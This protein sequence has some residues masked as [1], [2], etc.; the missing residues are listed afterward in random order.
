MKA[1]LREAFIQG[2][3]KVQVWNFLPEWTVELLR[4]TGVIVCVCAGWGEYCLRLAC[5]TSRR[6]HCGQRALKNVPWT[7]AEDVQGHIEPP[8]LAVVVAEARA[9]KPSSSG[10]TGAEVVNC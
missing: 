8:L 1:L 2:L 7:L 6:V 5:T 10:E 4:E 3:P 9:T